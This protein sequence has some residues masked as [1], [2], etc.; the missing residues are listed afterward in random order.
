MFRR[1]RPNESCMNRVLITSTQDIEKTLIEAYQ[2]AALTG[3]WAQPRALIEAVLTL[4]K[5]FKKAAE[6][7]DSVEV[8]NT[9]GPAP[10]LIARKTAPGAELEILDQSLFFKFYEQQFYNPAGQSLKE[11]DPRR[12][13]H[14]LFGPKP[15]PD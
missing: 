6:A 13:L 14:E 11:I 10:I 9:D 7:A 5:N 8:W 1:K 2:H 12:A 4:S 15:A 3:Q